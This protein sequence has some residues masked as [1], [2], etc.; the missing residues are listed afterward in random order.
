M[1]NDYDP[2]YERYEENGR[3]YVRRADHQIVC[4][5]CLA[6]DP[7]WGYPAAE[8]EIVG[9]HPGGVNRSDDDW[10]ACEE[11][12][13]LIEAHNVGGLVERMATFQPVHVPPNPV[14]GIYYAPLPLRRR[15]HRRNVLRFMDARKGPP[16]RE[17]SPRSP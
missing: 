7:T 12:H 17:Q 14:L 11:C 2:L 4:D 3:T 16:Y 15:V 5:F 13:A 1:S 8:M 9:Q 10:S 6:P